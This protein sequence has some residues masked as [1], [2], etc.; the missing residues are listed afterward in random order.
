MEKN[1]K[2]GDV[3]AMVEASGLRPMDVVRYS[4]ENGIPVPLS[5][6]SVWIKCPNTNAVKNLLW[7]YCKRKAASAGI[8]R[9]APEIAPV[10]VV[11][12][13][14]APLPDIKKVM[15]GRPIARKPLDIH[16]T[17]VDDHLPVAWR[18]G[19][20]WGPDRSVKMGQARLPKGG[21]GS[22]HKLCIGSDGV[23]VVL[24]GTSSFVYEGDVYDVHDFTEVE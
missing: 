11:P 22:V 1:I 16:I 2:D 19:S 12:Q 15:N 13:P 17:T 23:A 10:Q 6:A 14:D 3:A 20:A 24:D 5:Q 18:T 21:V 7:V 8:S 9:P 4:E